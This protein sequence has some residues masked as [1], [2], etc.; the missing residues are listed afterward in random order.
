MLV[1]LSTACATH[2]PKALVATSV[3]A[4][5]R[6][7]GDFAG[8][9]SL[10]GDILTLQ[11]N[12]ARVQYFGASA[13]DSTVLSGVTL[14]LV[15]ASDSSE[16]GI[17]L[18]VSGAMP[19]ADALRVGE[20]RRLDGATLSVPLPPERRL[21]DLWIAFQFRG[22]LQP[23]DAAPELLI[24]YVC[25]EINLMGGTRSARARAR[26]MRADYAVGCGL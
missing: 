9:V 5:V 10:D 3:G 8:D 17:P 2:R 19:V 16:R 14:R 20:E 26:R 11:L 15:V 7:T 23:R 22:T 4:P 24:A 12:R 6:V 13:A 21:R 25:S 1:A 18:G